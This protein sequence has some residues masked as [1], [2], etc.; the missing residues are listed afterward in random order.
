MS[1]LN[2]VFWHEIWSMHSMFQSI[3]IIQHQ[4]DNVGLELKM[5]LARVSLS[6][7]YDTVQ[8]W[9]HRQCI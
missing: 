6:A 3:P 7:R 4:N 5:K 2:P 9:S 1:L 8:Q